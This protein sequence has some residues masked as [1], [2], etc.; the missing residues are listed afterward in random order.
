MDMAECAF[1]RL[2]DVE[3]SQPWHLKPAG[4][5][6]SLLFFLSLDAEKSESHQELRVP[7]RVFFVVA[8]TV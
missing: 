5:G 7:V 2:A 8:P 4:L 1:H 6:F 3:S